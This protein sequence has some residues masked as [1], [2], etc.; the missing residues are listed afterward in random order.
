MGSKLSLHVAAPIRGCAFLADYRFEPRA[1]MDTG[2][3]VDAQCQNRH[4]TMPDPPAKKHTNI[5]E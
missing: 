4:H 5:R 1:D 2:S 3:A